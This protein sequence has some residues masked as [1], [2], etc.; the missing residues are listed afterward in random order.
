MYVNVISRRT[1]QKTEGSKS[2]CGQNNEMQGCHQFNFGASKLQCEFPTDIQALNIHCHYLPIYFS[3]PKMRGVMRDE[4]QVT[5]FRCSLHNT[6]NINKKIQKH[7]ITFCGWT[8]HLIFRNI[9]SVSY[10]QCWPI[11]V[12]DPILLYNGMMN[13]FKAFIL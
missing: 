6:S 13:V 3:I 8:N 10:I 2:L 9:W 4:M 1:G 12:L 7:Q 11:P 5:L